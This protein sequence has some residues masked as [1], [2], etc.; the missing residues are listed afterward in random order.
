[1]FTDPDDNFVGLMKQPLSRRSIPRHAG[2]GRG[3]RLPDPGC[4]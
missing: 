4:G 1:M 3:S 2:P